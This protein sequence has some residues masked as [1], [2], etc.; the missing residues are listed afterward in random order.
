MIK[1]V[2]LSIIQAFTALWE[3][4]FEHMAVILSFCQKMKMYNNIHYKYIKSIFKSLSAN[5]QYTQL[6]F[7]K[8]IYVWRSTILLSFSINNDFKLSLSLIYW[9]N[10][11]LCIMISR[12]DEYY[13]SSACFDEIQ[14]YRH[15]LKFDLSES[16]KS[17]DNSQLYRIYHISIWNSNFCYHIVFYPPFIWF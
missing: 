14:N 9:W 7:N 12:F 17:L 3:I 10:D 16:C 1:S 2:Q 13:Y 8:A 6:V 4:K 11:H 15:M 5:D